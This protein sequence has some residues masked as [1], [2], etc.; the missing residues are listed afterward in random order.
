VETFH[1]SLEDGKSAKSFIL[2]AT[3]CASSRGF[4]YQ[5][6]PLIPLALLVNGSEISWVRNSLEYQE[7]REEENLG[8]PMG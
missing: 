3:T 8:S 1:T 2:T 4:E 5:E 6:C 7:H